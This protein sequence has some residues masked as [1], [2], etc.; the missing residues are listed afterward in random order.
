MKGLGIRAMS[1][2]YLTETYTQDRMDCLLWIRLPRVTTALHL[3]KNQPLDTTG[4]SSDIVMS[5][6]PSVGLDSQK[7]QLQGRY[8]TAF[9]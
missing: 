5:A 6:S 1:S 4:I 9:L 8:N 2:G 7:Q 3:A